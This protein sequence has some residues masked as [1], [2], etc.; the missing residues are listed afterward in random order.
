[1]IPEPSVSSPSLI[2]NLPIALL[3][4]N[5]SMQILYSSF[6]TTYAKFPFTNFLGLFFSIANVSS[7]S[8]PFSDLVDKIASSF[9]ILPGVLFEKV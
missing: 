8:Y 5:K 3:F 1:M 9:E 2:A 6:M 7:P 4:L